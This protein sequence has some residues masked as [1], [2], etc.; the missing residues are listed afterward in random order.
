M[1]G[2]SICQQECLL[3]SN[4]ELAE[5]WWPTVQPC[6]QPDTPGTFECWP[7][8]RLFCKYPQQVSY[9]STY[10]TILCSYS[11]QSSHIHVYSHRFQL[12][13]IYTYVPFSFS[14]QCYF[15]TELLFILQDSDVQVYFL[16]TSLMILSLEKMYDRYNLKNYY[17]NWIFMHSQPEKI[18]FLECYI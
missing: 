15:A 17:F 8:F 7:I 6:K 4:S 3:P 11:R 12:T 10:S 1:V 5:S 9:A 18:H 13:F 16:R 14:I 2:K